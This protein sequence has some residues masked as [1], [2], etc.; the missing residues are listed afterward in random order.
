MS[1]KIVLVKDAE[2]CFVQG[3]LSGDLRII[4]GSVVVADVV[5]VL[6]RKLVR[7]DAEPRH[8]ASTA[9]GGGSPFCRRHG[10]VQARKSV[11]RYTEPVNFAPGAEGGGPQ[12][13]GCSGPC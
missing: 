12:A 4:V 11:I 10:S 6:M 3:G 5:D 2:H 9:L 7:G 13:G 1:I 8:C